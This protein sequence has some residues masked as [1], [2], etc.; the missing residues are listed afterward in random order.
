MT[1]FIPT[2]WYALTCATPFSGRISCSK[3]LAQLS[4]RPQQV[5][6]SSGNKESEFCTTR[7]HFLAHSL[8]AYNCQT[9]LYVTTNSRV[10]TV[11]LCSAI[12]WNS[13]TKCRTLLLSSGIPRVCTLVSLIPRSL[14]DFISQLW[15][16]I[17]ECPGNE[18]VTSIIINENIY[19]GTIY[20]L[21]KFIS[22]ISTTVYP[23]V[24]DM[25]TVPSPSLYSLLYI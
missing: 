25:E 9:S 20:H 11:V 2:T 19:M 8:W 22:V 1:W 16:K 3:S 14:P 10:S 5:G 15:N 4:V 21:S 17:W 13:H 24:T 7:V 23:D 6:Q 12:A 18:L